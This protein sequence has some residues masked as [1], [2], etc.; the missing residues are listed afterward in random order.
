MLGMCHF[1]I[2]IFSLQWILYGG[3]Q[4]V[5]LRI[6]Q[7]LTLPLHVCGRAHARSKSGK[8]AAGVSSYS[9]QL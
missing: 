4:P 3:Q 6:R 8:T 2:F 5:G 7:P 9:L 1:L